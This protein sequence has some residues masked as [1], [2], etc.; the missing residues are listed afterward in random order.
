MP[1]R[2]KA[3]TAARASAGI[4]HDSTR[5]AVMQLLDSPPSIEN[6][7]RRPIGAGPEGDARSPMR[8]LRIV[9]VVGSLLLAVGV[10]TLLWSTTRAQKPSF[11]LARRPGAQPRNIVL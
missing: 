1:Q 6:T 2:A 9:F 8:R 11:E 10:G 5:L 4:G 3:R 7:Q